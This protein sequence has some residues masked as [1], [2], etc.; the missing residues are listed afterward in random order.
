MKKI[1]QIFII[2]LSLMDNFA[3]ADS[4]GSNQI[5]LVFSEGKIINK[6]VVKDFMGTYYHIVYDDKFHLCTSWNETSLSKPEINCYNL[7]D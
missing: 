7:D 2:T 1:I 6:M 5:N 3:A 4:L